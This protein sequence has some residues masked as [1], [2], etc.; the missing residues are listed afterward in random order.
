MR[1]KIIGLSVLFALLLIS[2]TAAAVS[3][4]WKLDSRDHPDL[5]G[6]ELVMTRDTVQDPNGGVTVASDT[7]QTW[8]AEQAA[9]L[10]LAF[11]SS[12]WTG[13]LF[14]DEGTADLSASYDSDVGTTFGDGSGTTFAVDGSTEFRDDNQNNWELGDFGSDTHDQSFAVSEGDYLLFRLCV[15][16]TAPDLG[17]QTDGNSH[18]TSPASSSDYPT[19]DLSTL[20]LTTAGLAGLG[21]VAYRKRER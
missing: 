7:C 11:D 15:P 20:T 21:L 14:A 19:P 2:S 1:G 13:D 18:I 6:N 16:S 9:Q 3:Q 12:P 4:A 5:D 8:A 10:D 17:M